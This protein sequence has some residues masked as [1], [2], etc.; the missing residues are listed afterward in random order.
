MRRVAVAAALLLAGC[1]GDPL[2]APGTWR[3]G[4]SNAANLSF[5]V[6]DKQDLIR[7]QPD[8]GSDGQAAAQAIDRFRRDKLRPLSSSPTSSVGGTASTPAAPPATN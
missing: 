1:N 8:G 5:A 3:A 2:D 7:G 4:D 6:I